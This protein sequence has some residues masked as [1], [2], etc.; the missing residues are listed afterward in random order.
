[1]PT[2]PA[3]LNKVK[4]L[5]KLGESP[6]PHEAESAR[7]LAE[8]LI[9]KHHISPEELETLQ[10]PTPLYGDEEKLFISQGIV[11]WRQ[12]LALAVG[13]HFECQIV[14]EELVPKEGERQYHYYVYGDPVDVKKTQYAFRSFAEKIEHL[15]DVQCLGRGPI[16]VES[17]CEGV[18][19]AV[20]QNIL[21]YG[22]DI[23]DN[24]KQKVKAEVEKAITVSGDGLA[25]TTPEKPKPADKSVS[26]GGEYVKDIMAY[27][28][29]IEDG[30]DLFLE[31]ELLSTSTQLK[32]LE[33]ETESR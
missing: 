13:N 25:K 5:L 9:E 26:V 17:Y 3:I 6:N 16:Y 15:M 23:P 28:K 12:R 24:L 33:D 8:G 30:R 1:M 2:P 22:I 21:M 4:L 7:R 27:F 10:D 11:L 18:I 29:G 32:E 20:K 14:Q 31:E 19:D